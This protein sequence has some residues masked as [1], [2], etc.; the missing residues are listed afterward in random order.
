MS[1]KI[2]TFD[3]WD[4]VIKRKCHP[5]ETKIYTLDYLLSNY[6]FQI[7]EEYRNLKKLYLF[8]D[9]IETKHYDKS[10][11]KYGKDR[12]ILIPE[13]MLEVL[14]EVLI[15]SDE[16]NVV[17]LRDE[18]VEAE[19]QRE[20]QVTYVNPYFLEIIKKYKENDERYAISDFYFK[21]DALER[22]LEA[23]GVLKYFKKI[24]SSADVFLTK[25][26]DG[27][28]FN[29]FAEKEGIDLKNVIHSGDNKH[30]DIEMAKKA[31]ILETIHF[32]NPKVYDFNPFEGSKLDFKLDEIKKVVKTNK[33]ESLDKRKEELYN[34]GVDF[35][36]IAYFYIYD[37]I[38]NAKLNGYDHIYYQTR[39][40]ETFIKYH[41]MMAKHN[42]FSFD[43]L[44][45]SL[46][47][48]SRVATFS[49][50]LQ[51]FTIGEMLR[52]WS[53]Y[54]MQ[55]IKAMYK[56][57]GIEMTP[58]KKFFEKYE[59]DVE[60]PILEPY[61]DMK[62]ISLFND[63]E[64][65]KLMDEELKNKRESILEYL[66]GI[67]ITEETRKIY[68]VDIG[69]RGTIQDNLAY[70]LKNTFM[71]GS[72]IALF[73]EAYYNYQ[74]PNVQKFSLFTNRE[75]VWDYA[76]YIITIFEMLFN[77]DSGSV[78]GYKDGKAIRKA[79]KEETE[80]VKNVISNIQQ[81]MYEGAIYI[82]D[83]MKNRSILYD[84]YQKLVNEIVVNTKLKPSK[85]LVDV[86][87]GL[88]HNDTFG[89]GEYAEDKK[90]FKGLSR[91][92]ILKVRNA[93]RDELWKESLYV[94]N[95]FKVYKIL[96]KINEKR[97]V[98]MSLPYRAVRKC[99][100]IAKKILKKEDVNNKNS[101]ENDNKIK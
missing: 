82:N 13:V 32:P 63:E 16:E 101:K 93:L 41:Q 91:L 27:H 84:D 24:Y 100:R 1:K 35:A 92:N 33:K 14:K 34:L 17:K 36:P 15:E 96:F 8:R 89:T 45:S 54:R 62:V 64:Y 12:E 26:D 37:L 3:I 20:I 49:A 88:V 38:K 52:M 43:I 97:K 69:W 28:L 10:A 51:E 61:F 87:Y 85:L 60:E 42:P 46:I 67:G 56:S 90:Y 65:K 22:I 18:L 94:A 25:R 95:D 59:I 23:K 86:Y 50:S 75:I 83:Q 81:G 9:S 57:L 72:Y 73:E 30:S 68:L 4:T 78:I 80:Y 66:K 5:E 2:M 29:Y 19:L 74:R 44:G 48:V 47:E 39:E 76:Q 58:Y 53:Q 11:K 6:T 79:K 77:S 40:G 71:D 31:G 21:S 99:Y 55:S 70:I 98:V 7:K